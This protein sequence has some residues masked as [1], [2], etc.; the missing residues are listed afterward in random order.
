M[1]ITPIP[2][3]QAPFSFI[4]G[5]VVAY[6]RDEGGHSQ[7]SLAAG[8]G[9]SLGTVAR[10]EGGRS[11]LSALQAYQVEAFLNQEEV[12]T[13]NRYGA[14]QEIASLVAVAL[15][16]RGVDVVLGIGP[17]ANQLSRKRLDAVVDEVFDKWIQ[18]QPEQ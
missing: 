7:G 10:I 8:S 12:P 9:L 3:P 16:G 15:L 1:P 2:N 6:I 4:I 5:R 14:I 17:V 13:L 11:M 18:A